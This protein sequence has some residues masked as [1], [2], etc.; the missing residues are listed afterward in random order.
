MKRILASLA[1]GAVAA[2]S[3]STAPVV[4][5]DRDSDALFQTDSLTYTLRTGTRDWTGSIAIEFTN[6]TDRTVAFV[7]CN[8]QTAIVMQQRVGN[9]WRDVWGP[10][11]A[12]CLS[13]PITVAPGAVLRD[14]L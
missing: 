5:L 6:R 9:E 10:A 4:P 12:D 11:T 2:C 3:H 7:N 8:G 1:L 14:T 13:P